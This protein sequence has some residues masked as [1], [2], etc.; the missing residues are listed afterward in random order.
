MYMSLMDCNTD[1]NNNDDISIDVPIAVIKCPLCHG[2][3]TI[4]CNMKNAK[5]AC[6]FSAPQEPEQKCSCCDGKGWVI[7]TLME[8]S[9]FCRIIQ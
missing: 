2:S 4:L 5:I 1:R 3:G 6:F 7:K 9:K 8:E